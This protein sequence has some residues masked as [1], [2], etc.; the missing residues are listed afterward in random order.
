MNYAAI[1]VFGFIGY[2]CGAVCAR[3]RERDLEKDVRALT[4]R[5]ERLERR[6]RKCGI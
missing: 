5:L 6:A 4:E 3:W 2:L 1:A